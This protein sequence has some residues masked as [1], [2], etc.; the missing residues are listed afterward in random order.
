MSNNTRIALL[1]FLITIICYGCKKSAP[2]NVPIDPTTSNTTPGQVTICGTVVKGDGTA[3]DNTTVT[4]GSSTVT[5]DANGTYSFTGAVADSNKVIIKFSKPGYNDTWR[6]LAVETGASYANINAQFLTSVTTTFSAATGGSVTIAYIKLTMTFAA[7]SVVKDDGTAYTGTVIVETIGNSS[8]SLDEILP[9]DQRGIDANNN[10]VVLVYYGGWYF[11]LKGQ[12]G[13]VLKLSK[14]MTYSYPTNNVAA[15]TSLKLWYF[16]EATGL[17]TESA[18]SNLANQAYVGSTINLGFLQLAAPHTSSLLRITVKDALKNIPTGFQIK[19]VPTVNNLI[20]VYA[21]SLPATI[22]S[23]G[24]CL[25][26]VPASTILSLEL[27]SYC[28]DRV[29][30]I[31]VSPLPPAVKTEQAIIPILTSYLTTITGRVEDCT[32]QPLSGYAQLNVNGVIYTTTLINGSYKFNVI[33]CNVSNSILTVYDA[34]NKVLVQNPYV[35]LKAGT[36]YTVPATST[37]TNP[38]T[39][40]FTYVVAGKTYTLTTP[41]DQLSYETG[42][43]ILSGK[44]YFIMR[45]NGV[46]KG[47]YL[48]SLTTAA[49]TYPVYTADFY[50]GAGFDYFLT[51]GLFTPGNVTYTK[52]KNGTTLAEGTFKTNTTLNYCS[53]CPNAIVEVSGSFKLSQ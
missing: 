49:G 25:L 41:T 17:W 29:A 14:P 34:N 46:G 31:G 2:N 24:I 39:G 23:K 47:F 38:L 18:G 3:A 27:K 53:G 42:I 28:S 7:N 44:I 37:C 48:N 36:A 35:S 13:E 26:Y 12:A 32:F 43:D 5:T 51:W 10:P 11:R 40:T 30:L 45:G 20:D 9:G 52:F 22:N 21:G 1:L 4:I 16:N 50:G 15:P 19:N 8:F 33:A 6:T